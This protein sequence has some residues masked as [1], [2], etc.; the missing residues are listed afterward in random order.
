[1][2]N[3]PDRKVFNYQGINYVLRFIGGNGWTRGLGSIVEAIDGP[4]KGKFYKA[5][6]GNGIDMKGE[7]QISLETIEALV[8]NDPFNQCFFSA[9]NTR[10]DDNG[11]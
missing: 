3:S 11:Q 5:D 10:E 1:M 2:S 9:Q 7:I 8:K 4:N 6:V